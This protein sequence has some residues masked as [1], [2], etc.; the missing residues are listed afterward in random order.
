M[1]LWT[2]S[3]YIYVVL[4]VEEKALLEAGFQEHYT[5]SKRHHL[6]LLQGLFFS[7]SK[8]RSTLLYLYLVL[9]PYLTFNKI[10]W[11]VAIYLHERVV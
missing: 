11:H 3:E 5:L 9:V 7:E 6:S 8:I 2:S 1:S 10:L 4:L